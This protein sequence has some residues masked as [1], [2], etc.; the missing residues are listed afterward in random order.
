MIINADGLSVGART[1]AF[2]I[3]R[4][5]SNAMRIVLAY[6]FV[7]PAQSGTSVNRSAPL[8]ACAGSLLSANV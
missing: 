6:K 8:D 5:K 1:L 7:I 2:L 3:L 4:R